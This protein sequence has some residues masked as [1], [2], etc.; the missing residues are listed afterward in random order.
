MSEPSLVRSLIGKDGH[1][2]G[3]ASAVERNA[4]PD[5]VR[6][7]L[8][9][10]IEAALSLGI[11][12][13]HMDNHQGSVM[14]LNGGADFLDIV[15]ELCLEYELPFRLPVQITEQPFIGET[16][17]DMLRLRIEAARTMGIALPDDLIGMPYPLGTGENYDKMK[18][19]LIRAIRGARPGITEIVVH[20]EQPI[21]NVPSANS[22]FA[23]RELE[24][25]LLS[26][27]DIRTLLA[28]EGVRLLSWNH[29]KQW[30]TAQA[31][32]APDASRS[33]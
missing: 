21:A 30:Q 11:V 3:S 25:R 18:A 26:D 2:L 22:H 33:P 9:G 20:P 29:L 28:N 27:P 6:R 24:Y 17:K 8:R 13:T 5:E 19:E 10:Q 23:K 15:F 14:G 12:P 32:Q 4:D 7:E 16:V 31:A 1:F